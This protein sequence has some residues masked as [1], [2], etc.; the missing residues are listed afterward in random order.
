MTPPQILVI[1]DEKG[2]REM[3]SYNLEGMGYGVTMA[4]DGEEALTKARGEHFDVAISDFSMPKMSGLEILTALKSIDPDMEVII[5][6]GY[7]DPESAGQ[8]ESRGA[9]GSILKPFELEDF[10]KLVEGALRKRSQK[11]ET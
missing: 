9:Y 5:I 7:Q 11:K 6:T 1:D 10:Q 4:C 3:V 8:I 2:I